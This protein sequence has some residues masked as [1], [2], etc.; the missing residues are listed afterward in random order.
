MELIY[1]RIRHL[2]PVAWVLFIILTLFQVRARAEQL[3][4]DIT[5]EAHLS[6]AALQLSYSRLAVYYAA[7]A[8]MKHMVG[9]VVS[10]P[11]AHAPGGNCVE[12]IPGLDKDA[13][14]ALAYGP[15]QKL[16]TGTYA[17]FVRIK[18]LSDASEEGVA[19]L[20]ATSDF[21]NTVL[22]LQPLPGLD[23]VKDHYVQIPIFF[24]NESSEK[25]FELPFV[26]H[27]NVG[28]RVDTIS[29][30]KIETPGVN[31]ESLRQRA[32]QAQ[33]TGKPSNIVPIT[34]KRPTAEILPRSETPAE[35]LDVADLRQMP[36]DER[37]AILCLQGLVNR[38]KPRIYCI[39]IDQDLFWLKRM[40]ARGW[41]KATRPGANLASLLKAYGG[42][43]KGVV[44]PDPALPATKNLATMLAS[45]DELIVS[46]ERLLKQ[47]N[48]VIKFNL[49]GKWKTSEAVYAW[50]F[51]NLWPRLSHHVI[52]CSYPD[53]PF[54]RDY[55][56]ANKVFIFWISG[57]IDGARPYANPDKEYALMEH[58]LAKMPVNMPVLSYPYAGKDI[59][60]GEG[61]GVTLFAEFGKYLVGT[62]DTANLTVHSGIKLTQFKQKPA[63]P[64][65]RLD[66]KKKYVT[67]LISDGDNI[68]VLTGFNFP[69]LWSDPLRGKFPAAW[70]ISPSAAMLVPDVVDYYY[71]TSGPND[72][73]IAAVSG[74]GYTYPDS[75]GTRFRTPLKER[76]YD[77]FLA[78][79]A[80]YMRRMDQQILWPM[81]VTG[82]N[83]FDRYAKG[84]PNITG[85]FPDYGRRAASYAEAVTSVTGNVPVFSAV[86]TWQ[87]NVTD[88]EA[89]KLMVS[90]IRRMSP[91]SGPAFLHLFVWNWGAKLSV[92]QEVL[93]QLGPE[94]EAVR[95]DHLVS[96]YRQFLKQETALVKVP[97]LTAGIEGQL[98]TLPVLI[99]NV[100]AAPLNAKV[101]VSGLASGT[102]RSALTLF[103][104]R[105]T[106]SN[107]TGT[108]LGDRLTGTV[109]IDGKS[110]PFSAHVHTIPKSELIG[111][112]SDGSTTEYIE[113]Y[114]AI[115][116]SKRSGTEVPDPASISGKVWQSTPGRDLS[117][118]VV[119]GPY[120]QLPAG[121]YAAIFRIKCGAG[122]GDIC[123]IDACV[124]GGVKLNAERRI[125][126]ADIPAEAYRS[127]VLE[128]DHPGGPLETRINWSGNCRLDADAVLLFRINHKSKQ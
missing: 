16:P 112:I 4:N 17:A 5:S 101:T 7:I 86:T 105:E 126:A 116:L 109:N 90:D 61:P 93:S 6:P 77:G 88:A 122:N 14:K 26:W 59:G 12:A 110:I 120:K 73:W 128:F 125:S 119:Y 39:T 70:T 118:Y 97:E 45:T 85:I 106:V 40:Q 55:L 21:G 71:S 56:I 84:I 31:V 44:L 38:T 123:S 25:L 107:V 1:T 50:A 9:R 124:G 95:P 89:V 57:P 23:L 104:A 53:Q 81:N 58:L 49:K 69:Q 108:A 111:S 43:I 24:H 33:A 98:L 96:L 94:Y 32:R 74:I 100:T 54:L 2:L 117:G 72:A 91:S 13:G 66:R 48:L 67:F 64:A 82:W 18:L 36:A 102:S 29:L 78:Q 121:R 68:P 8:P 11:E 63:P 103:P 127:F 46:S 28:L 51:E 83:A 76:I 75:Y 52:A 60:V 92:L 115:D 87:E 65:P 79:T 35:I 114:T 22:T 27:G 62:T 99:Q 34:E 30:F 10:D 15:Y 80:E 47:L 42:Y 3:P 41:I 20:L 37:D 19:T 113:T